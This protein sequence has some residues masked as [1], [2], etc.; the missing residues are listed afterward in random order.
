MVCI[1]YIKCGVLK[2]L[3]LS[4]THR[5]LIYF[6]N[7]NKCQGFRPSCS[8]YN[9]RGPVSHKRFLCIFNIILQCYS[10]TVSGVLHFLKSQVGFF[11]FCCPIFCSFG[12][13]SLVGPFDPTQFCSV[14]LHSSGRSAS[15]FSHAQSC[16]FPLIG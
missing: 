5:Q 2:K 1:L 6:S 12:S 13:S 16:I 10:T 14:Q 7:L 15:F 9:F 11:W 8:I 3:N 4:N